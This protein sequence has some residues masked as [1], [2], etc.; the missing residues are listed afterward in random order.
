R[1][2]IVVAPAQLDL[3]PHD[4][5]EGRRSLDLVVLH[6]DTG[7]V[8]QD[9]VLPQEADQIRE[10]NTGTADE[11]SGGAFQTPQQTPATDRLVNDVGVARSEERRVGK[12]G[13]RGDTTRETVTMK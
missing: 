9:A 13:R 4:I 6:N 2:V 12:E 3:V 8:G 1:K 10:S 11:R 5:L 7:P